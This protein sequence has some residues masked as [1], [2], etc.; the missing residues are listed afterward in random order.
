MF[1]M[2]QLLETFPTSANDEDDDENFSK[3][4][5]RS[6]MGTLEQTACSFWGM[7]DPER[8]YYFETEIDL[9]VSS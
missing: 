7:A 8:T 6:Q 9:N 3:I 5:R 1:W 2:D 4:E